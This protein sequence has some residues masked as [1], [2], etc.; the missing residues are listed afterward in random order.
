MGRSQERTWP[1]HACTLG[2]ML[3]LEAWPIGC[4]RFLYTRRAHEV[5]SKYDLARTPVCV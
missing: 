3:S 5:S 2:S 4:A 1:P